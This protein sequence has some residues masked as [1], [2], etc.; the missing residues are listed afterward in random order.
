MTARAEAGRTGI[1]ARDSL[2]V[3]RST[4]VHPAA[5]RHRL[6]R[7]VRQSVAVSHLHIRPMCKTGTHGSGVLSPPRIHRL[8]R[9]HSLNATTM[10]TS[11]PTTPP[12]MAPIVLGLRPLPFPLDP[13]LDADCEMN[14]WID[15]ELSVAVLRAAEEEAAAE[16]E[17][18]TLDDDEARADEEAADDDAAADADDEDAAAEA[19]VE[20]DAAAAEVTLVFRAATELLVVVVRA[21]AAMVEVV[22]AAMVVG[23]RQK[24]R[25]VYIEA[26]RGGSEQ[27]EP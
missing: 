11:P 23:P 16:E 24:C 4:R 17:E 19:D 9:R 14:A 6:R 2:H 10:R 20:E 7:A 22:R 25:A 15:D 18:A 8:L 5:I 13:P 21:A 26:G 1:V 12:T 3:A 27:G